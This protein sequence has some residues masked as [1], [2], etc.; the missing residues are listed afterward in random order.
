MRARKFYV[1]LQLYKQKLSVHRSWDLW[2]PPVWGGS[3]WTASL[4]YRALR[5]GARLGR[6]IGRDD[7][8]FEYVSRAS[9]ILD[10]LQASCHHSWFSAFVLIGIL[11][12]VDVLE[13][14][15]RIY[16]RDY[17]HG[18]QDGRSV[19]KGIGASY[20]FSAQL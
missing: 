15:G 20:S 3:Y 13:R 8:V 4:Q 7:S 2:W 6:S 14:G 16:E 11:N 12:L 17:G 9:M 10:Y 1:I 19:W 18:R 5:A